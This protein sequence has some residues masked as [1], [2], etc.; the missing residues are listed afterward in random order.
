MDQPIAASE[1]YDVVVVGGGP[2]GLSA[3]LLLGR[4]RRRVLICDTGKPRNAHSA[5]AHGFLTR[6][7][8]APG[9]LLR[10]GRAEV[11]QYGVELL[12]EEVVE[13]RRTSGAQEG[14]PCSGFELRTAGGGRYGARKLLLATGVRDEL[15]P[16]E[17]LLEFY[18]RSVHHCPYCDGWEHRDQP[19]AAYGR[20][21]AAVGLALSLRNWSA[22]ITACSD[23]EQLDEHDRARLSRC[24][25]AVRTER[26]T[27]LEGQGGVLQRVRFE[28]GSPLECGALFFNTAQIPHSPLAESLGCEFKN[29]THVRS[30][31]RQC[32]PIPGVF[33]AGDID[34]DV[35]FL[36]VAASEGA[37]A[38]VAINRELQEEDRG[39]SDGGKRAAA[40][41]RV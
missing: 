13:A 14:G 26:L 31:E 40:G 12:P 11:S 2:A 37:Q 10:L 24:G 34:G 20:G 39:E 35:Q 22:H 5:H 15:P 38:A 9:E 36:V 3:A 27:R 8:I 21:K 25:I 6:D 32:S 1:R 17:G 16:V 19:L 23:G 7:G 18:G 4:C 41:L 33:L 28:R 29:E 30:S